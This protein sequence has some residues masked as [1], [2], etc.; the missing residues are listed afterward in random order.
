MI[1]KGTG[2]Y[3]TISEFDARADIGL[4]GRQLY[5]LRA[6]CEPVARALAV[7]RGDLVAHLVQ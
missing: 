7:Q 3:E 2:H 4:S 1:A 5:I 6:K